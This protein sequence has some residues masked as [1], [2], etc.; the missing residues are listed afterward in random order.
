MRRVLPLAAALGGWA[1]ACQV[2]VTLEV[3]TE[4]TLVDAGA[5]VVRPTNEV[6]RPMTACDE[7]TF[8]PPSVAGGI[9]PTYD[10]ALAY[11]EVDPSGKSLAGDA[12]VDLCPNVGFDLDQ[13]RTCIDD[14]GQSTGSAQCPG[15]ASGCAWGASCKNPNLKTNCDSPGGVDNSFGLVANATFLGA[16]P[17]VN[18]NDVLPTAALANGSRNVLMRIVGYDGE[19]DDDDVKIQIFGSTGLATT[20]R[21]LPDTGVDGGPIW[22]RRSRREWYIDPVTVH[23]GSRVPNVIADAYV[24]NYVLVGR[25][26]SFPMPLGATGVL[27]LEDVRI[28]G[29]LRRSDDSWS[30]VK[31]R[32]GGHIRLRPLLATIY[33]LSIASAGQ[34]RQ[35]CHSDFVDAIHQHA[36]ELADLSSDGGEG[37]DAISFGAAFAAVPAILGD[38]RAVSFANNPCDASVECP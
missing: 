29:E 10:V 26:A 32:I 20:T 19:A 24:H 17:G 2:F 7:T 3:T 5:D 12:G 11:L 28:A 35:I 37:C 1:I 18:P 4:P 8:A 13:K 38:K 36:C 31:G 16:I 14:T 9:G 34:L 27:S 6:P 30:I 21:A 15:D 25:A 33:S 22:D 23:D